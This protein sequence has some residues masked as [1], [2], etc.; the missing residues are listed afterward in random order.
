MKI[1]N[2]RVNN[3]EHPL[4]ISIMPLSFSMDSGRSRKAKRTAVSQ[5]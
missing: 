5:T 1:K 3:I 2:L 4:E